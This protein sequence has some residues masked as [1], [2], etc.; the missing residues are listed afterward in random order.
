[1]GWTSDA[2]ALRERREPSRSNVP[3]EN[4]IRRSLCLGCCVNQKLALI[5]K[6]GEP[7]GHI[8]RLVLND[9]RRDSGFGTQKSRRKLCYQFFATVNGASKGREFGYPFSRKAFPM[10]GA[11]G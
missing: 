6:L 3:A 2:R 7:A 9:R 1:M 10:A 5:S 8:G 4:V 11:M